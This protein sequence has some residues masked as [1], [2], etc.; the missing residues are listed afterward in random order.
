[1]SEV[2][3]Y[4]EA[5][6]GKARESAVRPPSFLAGGG[7]MGALIRAHDWATT[8]LGAPQDWPASLRTLRR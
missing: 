1:M 7:E 5:P 8:P 6:T 2:P 3:L 4:H